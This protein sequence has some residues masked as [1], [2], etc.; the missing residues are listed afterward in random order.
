MSAM[1]AS[2]SYLV[3]GDDASLV[4]Q[5]VRALLVE[6]VGERDHR[7]WS[8]SRRGAGGGHQR[9]RGRRASSPHRS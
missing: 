5:A 7:W 9:R 2:P 6:L 3:Q 4:A 8:R 1:T